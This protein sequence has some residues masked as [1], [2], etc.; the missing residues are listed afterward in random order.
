[1]GRFGKIRP[2]D[3]CML[4]NHCQ[5]FGLGIYYTWTLQDVFSLVLRTSWILPCS[6][7]CFFEVRVGPHFFEVQIR[8]GVRSRSLVSALR[9]G[10]EGCS[11]AR[12]GAFA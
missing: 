9:S 12:S 5:C 4:S 3:P 8:I 7:R 6:L 10:E 1:M 2:S 11:G